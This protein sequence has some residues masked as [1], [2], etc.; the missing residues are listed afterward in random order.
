MIIS[1]SWIPFEFGN[2]PELNKIQQGEMLYV[3]KFI[4][5]TSLDAIIQRA[6]KMR[7]LEMFEE[8]YDPP[9]YL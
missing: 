4:E 1:S 3:L 6:I 9:E 7:S 2:H 8:P 5:E